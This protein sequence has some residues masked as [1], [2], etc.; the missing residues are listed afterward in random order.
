VVNSFYYAK[1]PFRPF[2]VTQSQ[3]SLQNVAAKGVKRSH[4]EIGIGA[5]K[6]PSIAHDAG[7]I[8]AKP[9]YDLDLD[10]LDCPICMEHFSS[11]VFQV[12]TCYVPHCVVYG[13]DLA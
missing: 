3:N 11:P 8:T 13:C 12:L 6:A 1:I 9:K 7:N 10:T 4:G 2:L 5:G